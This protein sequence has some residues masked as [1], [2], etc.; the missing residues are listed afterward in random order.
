MSN[1]I[2]TPPPVDNDPPPDPNKPRKDGA[3]ISNGTW[4][5]LKTWLNSLYQILRRVSANDQGTISVAGLPVPDQGTGGRMELLTPFGGNGV[6]AMRAGNSSGQSFATGVAASVTN[7]T[8]FLDTAQAFNAVSGAYTIP[9]PGFYLVSCN[10]LWNSTTWVTN[11]VT[12]VRIII[13]GVEALS[14][15]FVVNGGTYNVGGTPAVGVFQLKAGD[16]VSVLT[17]QNSGGT[18]AL[19]AGGPL[20][21]QTYNNFSIVKIG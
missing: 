12:I 3:F 4:N 21:A 18:L 11:S 17:Q 8:T 20:D 7:Y 15:F 2:I 6:I 19:Y 13:N 1:F 14:T 10:V 5:N 16:G 9:T